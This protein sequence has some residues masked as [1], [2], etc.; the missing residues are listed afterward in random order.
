MRNELE[1][2]HWNKTQVRNE[3]YETAVK[4]DRDGELLCLGTISSSYLSGA[5]S[6]GRGERIMSVRPAWAVTVSPKKCWGYSSGRE[7]T[8]LAC[9]RPQVQLPATHTHKKKIGSNQLRTLVALPEDSQHPQSSSQ[10]SILPAT[11]NL[12]QLSGLHGHCTHGEQTYTK[13]KHPHI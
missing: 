5:E 9:T 10:L 7:N 8:C 13:A 1:K 12:T 4:Y 2:G 11:G 3:A 6:G